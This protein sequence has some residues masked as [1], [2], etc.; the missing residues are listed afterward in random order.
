[1]SANEV[2]QRLDQRFR[3]LTGT[4]HTAIERHQTLRGTIDW[5]YELLTDVERQLF[6]RL[7]TFAGTFTTEAAERVCAGGGVDELDVVDLLAGLVEKSMLSIDEVDGTTRFGLLESLRQ[8]GEERL[9]A[10]GE[11]MDVRRRFVEYHVALL[12]RADPELRGPD[13]GA[14]AHRLELEMDNLRST[15]E[16]CLA[17]PDIDLAHRLVASSAEFA[18][19][20]ERFECFD[21]ATRALELTDGDDHPL[22]SAVYG[23]AAYAMWI[24]SDLE[25]ADPLAQAGIAAARSR[26]DEAFWLNN[27]VLS[28]VSLYRFDIDRGTKQIERLAKVARARDDWFHLGYARVV[29]VAALAQ[30]GMYELARPLAEDVA[31]AARRTGNPTMHMAALACE[32]RAIEDE[33]PRRAL[34]LLEEAEAEASRVLCSWSEAFVGMQLSQLRAEHGDPVEA[35]RQVWKQIEHWRRSGALLQEQSSYLLVAQLLVALGSGEDAAVLSG[36]RLSGMRLRPSGEAALE[37]LRATLGDDRYDELAQRGRDMSL[38]ERRRFAR[39][40]TAAACAGRAP[41]PSS[42]PDRLGLSSR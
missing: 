14:W 11:S 34:E 7:S 38:D 23:M 22:R 10:S 39:D 1:M 18:L 13:E 19:W 25:A 20:R 33:E 41:R 24:R 35:M 37:G 42:S 6:D 2:L 15:A 16:W 28:A 17:E 30:V 12:E 8:Y 32:A 27:V 21:W 9:D 3:V 5:S 29:E 40:A 36:V 26:G 31:E 4:S